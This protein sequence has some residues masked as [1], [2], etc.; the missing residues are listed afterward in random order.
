[1]EIRFGTGLST[2]ACEVCAKVRTHTG[3]R[4]APDGPLQCDRLAGI[5]RPPAGT[6]QRHH[7]HVVGSQ[8]AGSAGVAVDGG[9]SEFGGVLS[10]TMS[11]AAVLL[12][13]APA[14]TFPLFNRIF[15]T[16]QTSLNPARGT[17]RDVIEPM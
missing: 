15:S 14:N 7:R 12:K 10:T 17:Q 8:P 13:Y 4:H 9:V 3:P 1:V 16:D 2:P 6:G 5:D 11:A